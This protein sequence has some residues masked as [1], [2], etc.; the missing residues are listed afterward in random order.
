M[1]IMLMLFTHF[2]HSLSS[3]RCIHVLQ[4]NEEVNSRS[5]QLNLRRSHGQA[6]DELLQCTVAILH[7]EW[8]ASPT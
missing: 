6:K 8:V 5:H 2:A 1:M 3:F 4:P 7:N